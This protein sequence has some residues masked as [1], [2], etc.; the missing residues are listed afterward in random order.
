MLQLCLNWYYFSRVLLEI[1]V[2]L[3][4]LVLLVTQVTMDP[5]DKEEKMDHVDQRYV[6]IHI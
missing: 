6:L 2:L 4:Q 3:D 5:K 1:L